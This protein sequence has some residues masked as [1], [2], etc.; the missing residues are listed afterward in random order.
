[1]NTIDSQQPYRDYL[2]QGGFRPICLS[3]RE[4]QHSLKNCKMTLSSHSPLASEF[5]CSRECSTI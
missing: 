5:I 4:W 1:M 2:A 3:L